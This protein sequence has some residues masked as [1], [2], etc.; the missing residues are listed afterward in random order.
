M[1]DD[2]RSLQRSL[3]DDPVCIALLVLRHGYETS[4]C[5]GYAARSAG[6]MSVAAAL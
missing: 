2:P 3:L 1:A 4:G 6:R 5:G